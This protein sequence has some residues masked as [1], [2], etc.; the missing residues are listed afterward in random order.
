M[1][2]NKIKAVFS[3]SLAWEKI[4]VFYMSYVKAVDEFPP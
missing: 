4:G 2:K 3:Y 1:L